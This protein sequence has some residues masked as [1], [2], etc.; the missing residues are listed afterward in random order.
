VSCGVHCDVRCDDL[1]SILRGAGFVVGVVVAVVAAE[2]GWARDSCQ[3]SL[4]MDQTGLQDQ[5][6]LGTTDYGQDIRFQL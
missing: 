3:C 1:S 2:P 5:T 4:L 6:E